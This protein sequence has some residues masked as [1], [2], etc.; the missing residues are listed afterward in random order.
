MASMV[1]EH[2]NHVAEL[3]P[4]PGPPTRSRAAAA[5][6]RIGRHIAQAE[7]LLAAMIGSDTV[8]AD[9]LRQRVAALRGAHPSDRSHHAERLHLLALWLAAMC[10]AVELDSPAAAELRPFLASILGECE[11][12]GEAE[13]AALSPAA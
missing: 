8:T 11:R 1:A 13:R 3:D 6:H 12:I 2:T 9:A 5:V 7:P 4:I 10:E